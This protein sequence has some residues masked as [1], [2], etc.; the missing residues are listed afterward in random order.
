LQ[1]PRLLRSF[2]S[3]HAFHVMRHC[4]TPCG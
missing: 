3:K 2:Y 1:E 4:T